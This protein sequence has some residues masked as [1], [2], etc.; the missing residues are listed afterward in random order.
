MQNVSWNTIDGQ[1]EEKYFL[2][3]QNHRKNLEEFFFKI[4]KNEGWRKLFFTEFKE[5]I[6]FAEASGKYTN[7]CVI[8]HVLI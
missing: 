5:G 4:T 2:P 6:N 3:I 1:K 8:H 7:A